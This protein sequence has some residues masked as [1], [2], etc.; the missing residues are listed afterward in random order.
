DWVV[1]IFDDI[2]IVWSITGDTLHARNDSSGKA[3][4]G[5][6]YNFRHA[7]ESEIAE[8]KERRFWMNHGRKWRGIREGDILVNKGDGKD[9]IIVKTVFRSYCEMWSFKWWET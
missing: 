3:S 8:E 9:W 5:P 4:G 1:D 2:L 6:F 7:T